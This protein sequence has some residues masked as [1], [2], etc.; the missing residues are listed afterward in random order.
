MTTS[1]EKDELATELQELYLKSK[2]WISDL[3][4]QEDE[5]KFLKMLFEINCPLLVK[6][7]EF[8]EISDTL[9]EAAKIEVNHLRLKKEI[10]DF[11]DLLGTLIKTVD[12]GIETRL[13]QWNTQLEADMNVNFEMVRAFKKHVFNLAS[14]PA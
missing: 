9:I 10:G 14:E 13:I 5:I 6:H 12:P 3:D 1:I 7:N 11:M 8:E 2:E 4:F